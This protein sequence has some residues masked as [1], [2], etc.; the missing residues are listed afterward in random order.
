[1]R[2]TLQKTLTKFVFSV[3]AFLVSSSLWLVLDS[4]V[5]FGVG[6]LCT[7]FGLG[8][9]EGVPFGVNVGT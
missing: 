8:D 5:V 4:S 9:G 2:K 3:L 7:G 1:V 6:W